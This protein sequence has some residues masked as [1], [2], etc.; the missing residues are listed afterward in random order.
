MSLIPATDIA[1]GLR[2][3]GQLPLDTKQ[4]FLTEAELIDLGTANNL[5]Y[6]YYRYLTVQVAENGKRYTW[7]EVDPVSS[8]G[9]MTT[10]FVYPAGHT[11]G[12][13]DYGGKY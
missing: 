9:L 4:Y 12:G 10:H 6:T 5:A 3:S 11:A 8:E 13:I 2:V 1:A 7:E